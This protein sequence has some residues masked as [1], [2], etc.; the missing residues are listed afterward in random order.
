VWDKIVSAAAAALLCSA[1][2]PAQAATELT[3]A[4]AKEIALHHHPRIRSAGLTA[5]AAETTVAQARAPFYPMLSGS[6]TGAGAP[7]NAAVAAGALTTSSLSSRLGTGLTFSQLIT[8]FGR[9]SNLAASAGFKAAALNRSTDTTR[10]QVVLEVEQSYFQAQGAQSVLE[11]ARAALKN[12]QLTLRQVRALAESSFKSTLDVSFAEVGVSEAELDLYRAENDVDAAAARLAAALGYESGARFQLADEPMPPALSGDPQPLIEEALK[13]RPDLA[14]LA[15]SRDAA[16]RYA[17]AEKR[18]SYPSVSILGMTGEI[19]QHTAT[20]RGNYGAAGINLTIPVMNGGLFAARRNE[21]ELK[22]KAASADM[23]DLSI[24]IARDVRLAFLEAKTAFRRLDVT[25]RLV[26]ETNQ[27][28][29]LA[30]VR[31][32][33]GLGSIV[34]LNQAQLNQTSAQIQA[35]AARY[36]YLSRRAAL[37]YATGALP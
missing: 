36:E 13:N 32:E 28:L 2:L 33:N 24:R 31:Y 30:Q 8:D 21:A 7:D 27:A 20:F 17:E 26:A 5:A 10:A 37:D 29:R 4:R 34:E 18:L 23:E 35:A 3:L 11:A 9:T 1:S 6:I 22:S 16:L 12:R 14:A 19:P 25:D 15:L